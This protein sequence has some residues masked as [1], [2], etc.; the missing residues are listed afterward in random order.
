MTQ[1]LTTLL[2]LAILAQDPIQGPDRTEVE[3][4]V[5][6]FRVNF[7]RSLV[8]EAGFAQQIED[9]LALVNAQRP[10]GTWA[11]TG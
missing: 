1:L 3:A 9:G 8:D 5:Q 4:L 2:D 11:R 10:G 6:Q 7:R